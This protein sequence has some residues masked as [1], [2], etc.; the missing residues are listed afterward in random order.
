[1]SNRTVTVTLRLDDKVSGGLESVNSKIKDTGDKA[2]T[3]GGQGGLKGFASNLGKISTLVQAG[4]SLW[5]L[6]QFVGALESIHAEGARATQIETVFNALNNEGAADTLQKLVDATGGIV[7]NVTLMEGANLMQQMGL[8]D[9]A[10]DLAKMTEMAVKLGAAMGHDV[11]RSLDDF[12]KM[13]ANQSIARLDTFG[14]SSGKVRD[15]MKELGEEFP[16]MEKD[17][18]FMTATMELG[19]V[20]MNRLGGAAEAGETA[21]KRMGV[22]IE[23]IKTEAVQDIATGMEAA[24]LAVETTMAMLDPENFGKDANVITDI[25]APDLKDDANQMQEQAARVEE[26]NTVWQ[27]LKA[28][29]EM[30]LAV[31]EKYGYSIQ[32]MAAIFQVGFTEGAMGFTEQAQYLVDTEEKVENVAAAY[33][34]LMAMQSGE[35]QAEQNREAFLTF[36][37]NT[38]ESITGYTEEVSSNF[39]TM[40]DEAKTARAGTLLGDMETIQATMNALMENEADDLMTW[41]EFGAYS[42]LDRQMQDLLSEAET[43]AELEYI[44]KEDLE[45]AKELAGSVSD[46]TEDAQEMAEAIKSMNLGELLGREGGGV[47][48][49]MSD[50]VLAA[51]EARGISGEQLATMGTQMDLATGRESTFGQYYEEDLTPM[52][53]AMGEQLGT[54]EMILAMNN[55]E[56][57]IKEG[58]LAGLSDE[59]M[60]SSV[61]TAAG[62]EW[63]TSTAPYMYGEQSLSPIGEGVE[64]FGELDMEPMA[65]AT[66]TITENLTTADETLGQMGGYAEDVGTF[67]ENMTVASEETLGVQTEV[68]ALQGKLDALVSKVYTVK[69]KLDV[70]GG[71]MGMLLSKAVRDNG[72]SVPGADSRSRGRAAIS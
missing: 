42:E 32:E 39:D 66:T 59:E 33:E 6:N 70:E 12:T 27:E 14:I 20:A 1:M 31:A 30:A 69:V 5:G 24:A 72:G 11:N 63:Q 53:A 9:N 18:R 7:D 37:A 65:E 22:S 21:M 64:A 16:N 2:K 46:M 62:Y 67:G 3:A 34:E 26:M 44:D 51:L 56:L 40:F 35:L 13:L 55:I 60:I 29:E 57:A 47:L 28:N 23:N 58:R 61:G 48:G 54:E 68:D 8:A 36:Y 10:D 52:L 45:A 25:F 50:D 19:E 15:R 17:V 38:M 71:A 41:G 4:S 49:E 43:L